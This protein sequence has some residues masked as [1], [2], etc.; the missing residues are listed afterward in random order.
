M[1]YSNVQRLDVRG[2]IAEGTKKVTV[3]VGG[4]AGECAGPK[5][6][7]ENVSRKNTPLCQMI[8]RVKQNKSRELTM[9]LPNERHL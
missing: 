3:E 8:L 7:E 9:G 5:V 1:R 6:S 2:Q 4:N